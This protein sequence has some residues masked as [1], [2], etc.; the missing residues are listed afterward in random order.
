MSTT[1]LESLQHTL[2]LTHTWIN[3]LDARL[4]WNNKPRAYR[5]LKSVLH[6]LRDW[7][8]L[9]E[10]AHLGAQLPTL[11][12]GAYYE[13]WQPSGTPVLTRNKTAFL[14]RI[15]EEFRRDPL[16]NTVQ[17]VMA[18]FERLSQKI[19]L[20]EIEHVRRALPDD[21]RT[22]WPEPYAAPGAIRS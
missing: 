6:V 14:T 9:N 5:P 20:G 22:V 1:G 2:E 8:Q 16:P 11:L 7:L 3:D 18:V 13:Q 19:T 4:G 10:M 15:D 21:L 12:R 17:A